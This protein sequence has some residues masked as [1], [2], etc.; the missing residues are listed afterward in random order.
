MDVMRV[1]SWRPFSP[2]ISTFSN[3]KNSV[4][5]QK[6]HWIVFSRSRNELSRSKTAF[7]W[8]VQ[9]MG[10]RCS[11]VKNGSK[12]SLYS[13]KRQRKCFNIC[14]DNVRRCIA[15]SMSVWKMLEGSRNLL[16]Y[17]EIWLSLR[18]IIITVSCC[19]IL[20]CWINKLQ[21]C[22]RRTISFDDWQ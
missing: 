13:S 18:I 5:V 12:F 1:L 16:A 11:S 3:F 8:N 14:S 7:G 21:I 17:I 9:Y 15:S 2:P 19:S 20:A 4:T 6:N 22:R 10:G